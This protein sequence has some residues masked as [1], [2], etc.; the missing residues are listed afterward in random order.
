MLWDTNMTMEELKRRQ[1]EYKRQ[2]MEMA[3]KSR[4]ATPK[5][6]LKYIDLSR[7][8]D[9]RVEDFSINLNKEEI[10]NRD[11]EIN[12]IKLE[13]DIGDESAQKKTA[14]ELQTSPQ[15]Q[16]SKRAYW[17]RTHTIQ[18]HVSQLKQISKQQSNPNPSTNF[19]TKYSEKLLKSCPTAKNSHTQRL[20]S[21]AAVS[22]I[23]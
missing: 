16:Q 11:A 23:R 9:V 4:T 19:P 13:K 17:I 21:T 1:E 20:R 5:A 10:K 7:N 2:A 12:N 15:Q 14:I 22:R 18:H 8:D 3:K 6:D